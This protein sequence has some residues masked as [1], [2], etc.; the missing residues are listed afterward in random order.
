MCT[1]L[2]VS[3]YICN[4]IYTFKLDRHSEL[5]VYVWDATIYAKK[6]GKEDSSHICSLCVYNFSG[7]V[8]KKLDRKVASREKWG[9]ENGVGGKEGNLIFTK[10]P[11]LL[12]V[13]FIGYI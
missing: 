10:S 2:N 5:Y 9:T 13:L 3:R 1:E 11:L 8:Y 7:K 4:I 12:L 6:G